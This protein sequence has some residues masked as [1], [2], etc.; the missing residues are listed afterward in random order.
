MILMRETDPSSRHSRSIVERVA[1]LVRWAELEEFAS[2]IAHTVN[3]PLGA[4]AAFAQ[5]GSRGLERS[6]GSTDRAAEIF[7]EIGRIALDAGAD[8]RRIRASYT[9]GPPADRTAR[10]ADL[11]GEIRPLLLHRA[12]ARRAQLDIECAEPLPEV[13]VDRLQIQF[14]LLCLV[15]HALDAGAC[16]CAD[17]RVALVVRGEGRDVVT[18]VGYASRAPPD[19]HHAAFL[20]A[21]P[22]DAAG[23]GA[24]LWSCRSIIAAHGG[25]L[26]FD[27][28]ETGAARLSFRLPAAQG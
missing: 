3:Q 2:A 18:H 12:R 21:L 23:T 15:Q 5:A 27:S 13:R 19:E 14:V 25:T 26:D 1:E 24:H 11:I 7:G 22:A 17:V 10:P 8:I 20:P 6:H 9:L 4:I 28:P 16:A